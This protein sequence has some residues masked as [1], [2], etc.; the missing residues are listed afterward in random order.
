MQNIINTILL[1]KISVALQ[2]FFLLIHLSITSTTNIRLEL[3]DASVIEWDQIPEARLQN[4]INN[5]EA[6]IRFPVITN[7]HVNRWP[8]TFWPERTMKTREL[9]YEKENFTFCFNE[10]EKFSQSDLLRIQ[11]VK[12]PRKDFT[13]VKSQ[14]EQGQS[15][16][17]AELALSLSISHCLLLSLVSSQK[18][19]LCP[20]KV[21]LIRINSKL[22]K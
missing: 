4:F 17:K 10:R 15:T 1:Q 18:F 21:S 14:P 3:T 5:Q 13:G 19:T 8:L 12:H 2:D 20:L 16:Q 9:L 6:E 22:F 11:S 7:Y